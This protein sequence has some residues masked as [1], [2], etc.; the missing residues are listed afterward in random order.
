[1]K[2]G[3]EWFE[4]VE[5]KEPIF[6]RNNTGASLKDLVKRPKHQIEREL[7]VTL[8]NIKRLR[9]KEQELGKKAP[10]LLWWYVLQGGTVK[11][12]RSQYAN[13]KQWIEN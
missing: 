3:G 10:H 6:K 9:A 4:I 5:E 7:E 11:I 8:K 1:M 12:S 2:E 13:W